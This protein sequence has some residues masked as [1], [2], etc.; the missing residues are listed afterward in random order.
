MGQSGAGERRKSRVKSHG[1]CIA[2]S[3]V[4]ADQFDFK[5]SWLRVIRARCSLPGPF[6][7]AIASLRS[8]SSRPHLRKAIGIGRCNGSAHHVARLIVRPRAAAMKYRSVVPHD[9]GAVAPAMLVRVCGRSGECNQVRRAPAAAS[10]VI[11]S[12]AYVCDAM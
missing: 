7:C 10:F 6:V 5:L 8:Y 12:I 9:H 3:Y 2:E 1:T 4:I 11:P